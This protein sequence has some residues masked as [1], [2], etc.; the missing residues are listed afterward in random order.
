[1]GERASAPQGLGPP[2]ICR[3][4]P[5]NRSSVQP[6]VQ[7]TA[8]APRGQRTGFWLHGERVDVASKVSV[9]PQ[10]PQ[11]LTPGQVQLLTL[12]FLATPFAT[13]SSPPCSC[14]S[15]QLMRCGERLHRQLS[16]PSVLRRD[17]GSRAGRPTGEQR[18]G[19]G[20]RGRGAGWCGAGTQ[21]TVPC[22][23]LPG[24]G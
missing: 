6:W 4:S 2:R 16:E 5:W 3:R 14:P 1:M 10:L 18:R 7:R 9:R 13:P 24:L 20:G 12:T 21:E 19:C 22:S 17:I 11:P 8:P 23:Q 15:L